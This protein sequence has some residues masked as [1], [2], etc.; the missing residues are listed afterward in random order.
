MFQ[1]LRTYLEEK[2][3]LT[4]DQ[5]SLVG[6]LFVPRTLRKNE[7]LL[8]AGE[9][10]RYQA[11]VG[12]GCLRS[13]TVDEKGKEHVVYFAPENYWISDLSS[14]TKHE[15]SIYCIDALEDSDVLLIDKPSSDKLMEQVVEIR[16]LFA[17][18]FQNSMIA[19]QK[20]ILAVLSTPAEQR[21]HDF[22]TTYPTLTQRIPQHTIASYL[23]ITPES[24]SRIRRH[25]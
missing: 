25:R 15:P 11:F 4:E 17:T 2:I 18:L 13:Y 12:K 19:M 1:A 23:G 20:R 7:R 10:C 3:P 6:S 16:V 5:L 22:L 8:N 9:V 14:F 24:L 21:Y